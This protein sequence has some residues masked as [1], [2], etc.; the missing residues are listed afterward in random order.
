MLDNKAEL[1][2]DE[3][4]NEAIVQNQIL[5]SKILAIIF[6]V[7][8]AL[9]SGFLLF[10]LLTE[11]KILG[12]VT[13]IEIFKWVPIFLAV[14]VVSELYAIRYLKRLLQSGEIISDLYKYFISFI[15]VSF[16]TIVLYYSCVNIGDM[17]IGSPNALLNSPPT[18]MYFI[19]IILS[20]LLLEF[21]LSVFVGLIAALQ[22]VSLVIIFIPFQLDKDHIEFPFFIGRALFFALSGVVAGFVSKK[23]REGV[24]SS[25]QSKNE[26][27]HTLDIKVQERTAEVVKQKDEI[28]T[29]HQQLAHKNKEITDSINYA[30]RIQTAILPSED[31]VK[32]A[33]P[34]SFILF[35]PKDI[36]SGDFYWINR[37][38]D[39]SIFIA[40]DCTGHGVPGAFMSMI[41][42]SL[43]NKIVIE[44]NIHAT[45]TILNELKA[46]VIDTLGQTGKSGESRDG[47]DIAICVWN[48][49][50]N[51]L[52]YSGAYNSM[53]LIRDKKENKITESEKVIFH[54]EGL[55]EFK[56][57]KQPIG[58]EEGKID[59]FSE[60]TI[61]LQKGDHIYIFSDGYQDQFGGPKGKKFRPKRMR[62]LVLSLNGK[63]MSHQK[64]VFDKTIEEWREDEEQVDD[65]LII[66]AKV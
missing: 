23:I 61:D 51:T 31:K 36:V 45:N 22:F 8:F 11:G 60:I 5:K 2:Y 29:Q 58:F 19:F 27:I 57:D 44:R 4:L 55:I 35:K 16:P 47:M 63:D 15:E 12:V 28:E 43:L 49:E 40:A 1:A 53:Y 50:N 39:I 6:G 41:G 62:E 66:G 54:D 38:G 9:E 33:L 37:V 56:P 59:S 17:G 25:L 13:P 30:Q 32:E 42:N 46:D 65:I 34:D 21:R 52:Q 3:G 26:L 20:S 7:L 24:L 48:H 14:V 18:Y 10:L 64:E